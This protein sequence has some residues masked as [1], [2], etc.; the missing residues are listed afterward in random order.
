MGMIDL[1]KLDPR[2]EHFRIP[3]PLPGHKL[4]LRR[5][6]AEEPGP[7]LLAPGA[8]CPWRTFEAFLRGV[9]L[10]APKRIA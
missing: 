3:S 9:D 1:P 2:E 5:L 8:L 10:P 7:R 4:L 6:P